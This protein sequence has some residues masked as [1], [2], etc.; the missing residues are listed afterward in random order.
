MTLPEVLVALAIVAIILAFSSTMITTALRGTQDNIN[1][2]FATQKA[3]SMLEELR[4][5]VQSESGATAV[6]LDDYDDGTT[7]QLFLTTQKVADPSDPASGNKKAGG[8]W[9]FERRISVQRVK[10][11]SDV[12]LVNVRVYVRDAGGLRV[13]AEVA[14]V[15]STI[16]RNMPP[17]QVY[18]VYLVAIENVPGW[19]LYMQNIVPFVEGAMADLQARHPGLE[20]RK[21]WIR[22][23]SYGRDPFYTPYVNREEDSEQPVDSVYFYPGTL[24]TGEA[25]ESYYPPD[26]FN[27]RVSIDGTATNAYDATTNPLPYSLAD[28]YNNGVRYPEEKALFEARVNAKLESKDA[29]TLR[30]LFDDM[31]MHPGDYK[32]AILIN[33]HGELFPF[34]PVRNYS[35]PAKRPGD[36]PYVR[37]VTH[38]ETLHITNDQPLPLRVYTYHNNVANPGNV[39]DWLGKGKSAL[40]VTVVL[41]GVTWNPGPGEVVSITGGVD[42][43]GNGQ[44]DEYVAQNATTTPQT[45]SAPAQM[46]YSASTNGTDTEI[47]L[48][49]SPLKTPCAKT[50][51]ACDK[52]GLDPASRLYA[53]EYIPSPLENL[54]DSASPAP[55]T[56]N[57][58]TAGTGAKNTARWVLSV[59]SSALPKDSVITIETRIGDDTTS[60]APN[61]SRTYAWRGTDVW[62]FGDAT[63]DPNLPLTERFQFLGDP[64]HCPYADNKLPHWDSGRLRKDM[65]GMGYNRYFDDFHGNNVNASS[66]W[67]GWSY[68]GPA[69]SGN[70]FGIKNNTSDN[71][72]SNDGWSTQGGSAGYLEIDVHRIYQVLRS[73]LTRTN[74]VYTTLTGFSYYYVGIGNEIGYDTDNGFPNSIPVSSKPFTGGNGSQYEQ[75]IIDGGVKYIRENSSGNY[76]WAMTWL[77]ELYP[78]SQWNTWST[79]GNLPTGSGAGT[80]SRV[81]RSSITTRL[82]EGTVF[83]DAVR[84]T[85][86]EGSTT[87]FWSGSTKSTFHHRALDGTTGSL[88]ADGQDIADTY[89]LALA[90]SI[91]N[92]RPFDIDINDTSMNPDHF[93]Q[94][95]YGPTTSLKNLAEFYTHSSNIPGSALLA[96]RSD[97]DAA[98]VVVN[99]LSPTGESGVSFISRWSFVSLIQSFLASGLYSTNGQP[100]PA[101][102][103][104]L[105]RVAI[106]APNDEVDI[107]DPATVNVTWESTWRRW[108]GLP[109]TP[110]YPNNF[111]ETVTVRYAPLYSRDNGKTWLFM[112]DDTVATPGVRPASGYLQ[113][114][115]TFALSV[116]PSKFPKGNYL[117][118]VEAYR[119]EVPL[120]YSFHQ[121]R[122]FIKRS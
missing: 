57:L 76:W 50:T 82:P 6:V 27:G 120:H 121:Y 102:V 117:I 113:T 12:R 11:A 22:K 28:Q 103:R 97:K 52:G 62:L 89:K 26:F 92:R 85:R 4:A 35:D 23:L 24:P 119:D 7:N 42:L 77:G 38:P 39:A 72:Q 111:A 1:K 83:L 69:F 14:S 8:V 46:W 80:F 53:L 95:A 2:Q 70:W 61:L 98:F 56:T 65:V 34:P 21:H 67:T 94:N 15:L 47:R 44:P 18:D 74:A 16:G 64:R 32:N 87:F 118:R 33:L 106:T 60:G 75:S 107:V 81:V 114:A 96:M 110:N 63:H 10:G 9:L 78:D 45:T 43:D 58:A 17:T 105:P 84:R 109:Y 55:F 73:A 5:V 36:L 25:V 37:A 51:N 93:L 20:F 30:L 49:N 31:Y 19:W 54:P 48:Y 101:R 71:S 59:P 66:R 112:K 40:P 90:P 13:L 116:P 104:E 91:E 99:G 29:P 41:R 3:I 108:D 79:T 122:M 115:K 88:A 68:D 86:A 100:D